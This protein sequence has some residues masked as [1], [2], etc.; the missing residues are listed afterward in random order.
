MSQI[1]LLNQNDSLEHLTLS[2]GDRNQYRDLR[3]I[4]TKNNNPDNQN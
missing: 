4:Q 1:G 2:F 3:L